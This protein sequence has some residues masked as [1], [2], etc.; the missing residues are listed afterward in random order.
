MAH[1]TELSHHAPEEEHPTTTGINNRKLLMWVFLSSDCLFFGSLIATYM[2]YRGQSLVGPYPV[3]II[4]VPITTIS[5][6][7]LLCSSFA[8]VR[9]LAAT[10]EDRQGAIVVWLLLTAFLGAIFIGFQVYEFNLFREEGLRIDTNLFGSTFFTLT[11]FHGAHVTLGIVWL[12]ALAWIAKKG[13][14]GPKTALDVELAGLYWHFVD[15]VWIVIFTLLYLI[16]G[17]DT[18]PAGDPS[19]VPH[20]ITG[21]LVLI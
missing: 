9:A 21:F 4:D 15:I 1:H 17:F 16:G 18:G 10:N 6:F 13:R 19:L 12:L 2:V 11:G 14:L 7:V 5:T 3:D 20:S 8:M